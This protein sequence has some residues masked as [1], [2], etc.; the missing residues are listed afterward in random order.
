MRVFLLTL[1]FFISMA[2]YAEQD[3]YQFDNNQQAVRFE[4]LTKELRW[5]K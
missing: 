3:R 1:S 2:V 5:P 4:E